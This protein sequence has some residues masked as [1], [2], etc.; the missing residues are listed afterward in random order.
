MLFRASALL[1]SSV[2]V[3]PREIHKIEE[4]PI[5]ILLATAPASM[6]KCMVT[7]IRLV[8]IF[9]ATAIN[10][11]PIK[12]NKSGGILAIRMP[13]RTDRLGF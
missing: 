9:I 11:P 10:E 13:V 5:N 6:K 8:N 2:T 3:R 1:Q 4:I 7:Q 12:L